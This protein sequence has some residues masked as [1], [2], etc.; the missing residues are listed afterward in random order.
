MIDILLSIIGIL[1]ILVVI[2]FLLG[3]LI[4]EWGIIIVMIKKFIKDFK[5]ENR[6]E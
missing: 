2:S 5:F 4:G 3:V 6:E 1:F